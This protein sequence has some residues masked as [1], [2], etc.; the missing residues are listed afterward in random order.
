MMAKNAM[1]TNSIAVLVALVLS[2]LVLFANPEFE[3]AEM[4]HSPNYY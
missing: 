3:V 1:M 2:R 4:F